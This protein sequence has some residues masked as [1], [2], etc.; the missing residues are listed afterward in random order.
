[1]E[2][3]QQPRSENFDRHVRDPVQWANVGSSFCVE[4]SDAEK[5][6]LQ[7][8]LFLRSPVSKL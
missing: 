7:D 2:E 6:R 5:R 4:C 1:M 8:Y 3:I